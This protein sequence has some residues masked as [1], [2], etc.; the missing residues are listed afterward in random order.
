MRGAD[1]RILLETTALQTHKKG[2]KGK[3]KNKCQKKLIFTNLKK[4][5]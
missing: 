5:V 2:E 3:K 1:E 4:R